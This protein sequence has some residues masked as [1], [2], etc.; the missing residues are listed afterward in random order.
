MWQNKSLFF[1]FRVF[2]LQKST[3]AAQGGKAFGALKDKQVSV[4]AYPLRGRAALT[5]IARFLDVF[6]QARDLDAINAVSFARNP[7]SRHS[8]A[9]V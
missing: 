8:C 5:K 3:M 6:V 9:H 4:C 2:L 7:H 1:F